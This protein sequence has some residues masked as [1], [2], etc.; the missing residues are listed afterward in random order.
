MEL[1]R[2]DLQLPVARV[3]AIRAEV[4]CIVE[5][6]KLLVQRRIHHRRENLG[7]RFHF[8]DG[9]SGVVY[10]ETEVTMHEPLH[11]PVALLVTFRLRLVSGALH[12]L[13]RWES[14]LNTPLFVGFPGFVSKLWLAND[15]QGTY[16]GIYQW[17]GASAARD[18][19]RSLRRILEL[20]SVPGSISYRVVPGSRDDFLESLDHSAR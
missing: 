4:R 12:R 14:L 18:Y 15:E 19:A 20:V 8:E 16:R 3:R 9:T 11:E 10:R 6:C 2:I 5:T 7:R 13:F 17:D 1:D